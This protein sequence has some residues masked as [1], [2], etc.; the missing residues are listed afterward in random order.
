MKSINILIADDESYYT[1]ILASRLS[2]RGLGR[3]IAISAGVFS[4]TLIVFAYSRWFWLTAA[5]LVMTGFCVM[6]QMGSSNTLIQ[7][8][9]P[10]RLRG[11]VLAAY[12]MM[13]MGMAPIGA[14]LA[15]VL[16]DRIGAP[17]TV[18]AGG[19]ACAIGAG[20][21]AMYLPAIRR[22]AR[23]LILAQSTPVPTETT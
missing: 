17:A 15:G 7:S 6:M 18:A 23:E 19:I 14:L 10:D 11:R 9:T 21:F 16:A 1:D 4:V 5:L 2:V 22:E 20:V 3:W 13:L 8:M 12:S